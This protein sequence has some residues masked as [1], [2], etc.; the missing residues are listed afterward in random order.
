MSAEA[1]AQARA[2]LL[3][4]T[5]DGYRVTEVNTTDL[6]ALLAALDEMREALE[7]LANGMA[8]THGDEDNG[9]TLYCAR[10]VD[11]NAARAVLAK[12]GGK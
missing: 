10:I 12:A 5:A 8:R 3:R 4:S 2:E 7:T 9:E 6:R 1:I 11:V